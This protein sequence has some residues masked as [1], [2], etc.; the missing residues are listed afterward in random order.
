MNKE[1][2]TL[3]QGYQRFHAHYYLGE[4]KAAFSELV[5]QG[6]RPKALV[7][8]CSDSRVDPALLL[9]CAPGD[10][11][12]VRNVAN[13]VPPCEDDQH[14]YHGTSA[15][16]EFGVNVLEIPHVIVLGHTQCGGI[17]ALLEQVHEKCG[18][19]S[20]LL[21]WISLAKAAQEAVIAHHAQS[22]FE[23]KVTLC[24]QYSLINSLKN[25]QTFSW[26]SERIQKGTLTLQAWN[27]HLLTGVLEAYDA[28]D[29]QF[30]PLTTSP[31]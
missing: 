4:E 26:I 16:L 27:F 9:D 23:E 1:I 6:Q 25:L 8:A 2:L 17:Q 29:N 18:P 5:R 12:V 13:L 31:L 10:I 7:I 22:S 15:A 24:G 19:K 20:F 21:K 11:F 3:I 14:F 30:K 28:E